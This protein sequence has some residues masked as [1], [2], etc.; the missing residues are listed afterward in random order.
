[1]GLGVDALS[2]I[3][4]LMIQTYNARNLI[5]NSINVEELSPLS[6]H[7]LL[8]GNDV[9]YEALHQSSCMSKIQHC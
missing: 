7:I 6:M 4:E 9:L 3:E 8:V 1:M 2:Q 5:R